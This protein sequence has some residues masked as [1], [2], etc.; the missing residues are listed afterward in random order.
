MRHAPT[1]LDINLHTH[2]GLAVDHTS[3]EFSEFPELSSAEPVVACRR[4]QHRSGA[5]S[6]QS[7]SQEHFT[8]GA[9]E[10]A[11]RR[12]GQYSGHAIRMATAGEG[13]AWKWSHRN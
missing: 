1:L 11:S 13:A 10:R 4:S 12:R 5:S 3:S 9:N 6:P 7:G 2:S 8:A